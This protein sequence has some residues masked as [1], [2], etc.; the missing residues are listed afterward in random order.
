MILT[1]GASQLPGVREMA[2]RL[3]D[4]QVR[5]GQ[6]VRISRPLAA[7]RA[8]EAYANGMMPP[9]SQGLAEAASGP[10]FATVAGLL[11][12]ALQPS[13]TVPNLAAEYGGGSL[14]ERL[15][16]WFKQNI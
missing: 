12:I 15:N 13:V 9:T 16:Y 3:M 14:M 1:G 8:L 10:G 4:K 2:Q 11:A 5:L 7:Y 6:P